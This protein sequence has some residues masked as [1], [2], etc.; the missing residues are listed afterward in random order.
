MVL[1]E[2]NP[3]GINGIRTTDYANLSCDINKQDDG[4]SEKNAITEDTCNMRHDMIKFLPCSNVF[5]VEN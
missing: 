3:L 5:S 1:L 4:V 2:L